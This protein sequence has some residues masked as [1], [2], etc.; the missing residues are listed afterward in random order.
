MK[1]L[2]RSRKNR[3]LAGV[4]GGI[5]EYFEIDPVI[6]RLIWIVLT[7]IWGFGLILYIIAIFLIPVEPKEEKIRDVQDASTT[8]N[9]SKKEFRSLEDRDRNIIV[10][11]IALFF[12][13]LGIIAIIGIVVPSS[14]VFRKIV[15]GI[16]GITLIIV[17]VILIFRSRKHN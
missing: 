16:I 3:V 13:V 12:I 11:L 4:C 2:Y 6:V 17:G 10:T 8:I 15:K 9:E 7:M 1:K 5:G 14:F